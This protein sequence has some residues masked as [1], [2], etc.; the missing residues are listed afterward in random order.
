[1]RGRTLVLAI[2]PLIAFVLQDEPLPVGG[3]ITKPERTHFVQPLYPEQAEA[4]AVQSLVILELTVDR[5]GRV[6][7]VRPLR[8]ADAVVPAA[9]EAAKHWR[10]EPT[11]V[12]TT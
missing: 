3:N 9:V 2:V 11:F 12:D 6:T 5:T 4:S 10:Y 8:G 7:T 1:M